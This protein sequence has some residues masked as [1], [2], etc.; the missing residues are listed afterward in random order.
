MRE[1]GQRTGNILGKTPAAGRVLLYDGLEGS[2]NWK[3]V[4]IAPVGILSRSQTHVYTGD[5][6]LK[7]GC[8]NFRPNGTVFRQFYRSCVVSEIQELVVSCRFVYPGVAIAQG[9]AVGF[10]WTHDGDRGYWWFRYD[11][12]SGWFYCL[13]DHGVW[14]LIDVRKFAV[15]GDAWHEIGLV[16]NFGSLFYDRFFCDGIC[17]DGSLIKRYRASL[18]APD[19]ASVRIQVGNYSGGTLYSWIDDVLV[20]TI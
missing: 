9:F 11:G 13:N 7:A 15:S 6:A 1:D 2:L 14:E 16:V 8:E 4:G 12:Q 18:F 20:R 19:D 17:L 10:Y 5:W 3:N